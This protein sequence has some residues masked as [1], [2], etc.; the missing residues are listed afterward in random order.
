MARSRTGAARQNGGPRGE[1]IT[2]FE[3]ERG[4]EGQPSPPRGGAQVAEK[5]INGRTSPPG[6]ANRSCRQHRAPDEGREE[7]VGG[8]ELGPLPVWRPGIVKMMM[9]TQ[10]TRLG[11]DEISCS[12]QDT[13]DGLLRITPGS[14]DEIIWKPK[15]ESQRVT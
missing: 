15:A 4:A 6:T 7:Q 1:A 14:S 2:L 10:E 8:P 5:A 12:S 3:S 11:P 13:A 9:G